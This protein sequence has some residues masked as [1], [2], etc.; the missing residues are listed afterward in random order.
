MISGNVKVNGNLQKPKRETSAP[1]LYHLIHP[2]FSGGARYR[3]EILKRLRSVGYQIGNSV[4]IGIPGQT[5]ES[6]AGD[7]E[8]FRELDLDMVGVGP[9]IPHPETPVAIGE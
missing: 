9:Y 8:I 7:I 1:D 2:S 3:V 4:M 5:Y 6:L